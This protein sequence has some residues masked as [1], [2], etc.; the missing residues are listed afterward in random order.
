MG[1]LHMEG[2]GE[3]PA[4]YLTRERKI[5]SSIVILSFTYD[6]QSFE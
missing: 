5:L 4:F 3:L 1:G 2:L 6:N